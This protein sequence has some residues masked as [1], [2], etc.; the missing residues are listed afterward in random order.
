MIGRW[1][2]RKSHIRQGVLRLVKTV[3]S[4]QLKLLVGSDQWGMKHRLRETVRVGVTF[5]NFH[6]FRRVALQYFLPMIRCLSLVAQRIF[7][8]LGA[9]QDVT[10]SDLG[11]PNYLDFGIRKSWP[12]EC[13]SSQLPWRLSKPQP[14]TRKEKNKKKKKRVL[15]AQTP[16]LATELHLFTDPP[17]HPRKSPTL[18]LS[19]HLTSRA[20][21]SHQ[22]GGHSGKI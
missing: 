4:G 1:G 13:Q 8:P 5:M 16:S 12:C 18:T 6:P 19:F 14:P 20:W 10:S 17:A 22:Y 3:K 9:S 2:L 21:D 7:L 15:I 11:S